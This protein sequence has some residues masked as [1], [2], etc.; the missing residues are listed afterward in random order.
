MKCPNCETQNPEDARF[1]FNCGTT[2]ALECSN[3]GTTLPAKAKF[4]FNCGHT[5]SAAEKSQPAPESTQTPA[6]AIAETTV[7]DQSGQL[8][9]RYIPQ[10][11][12]AK[13]EAAQKSGLMEGERRIVTIL[14]CDLKGSTSA[15][16]GLDPEE[17]SEIMNGAFEQ[18]IEPIYRYEGTVARLMGDGLLAFFGAPIA[19]EDD[20]QRAILAGLD[21]IQSMKGYGIEIKNNWGLALDV[22]VG[23]NTGLVVVGAVGSEGGVGGG[24][25]IAEGLSTIVSLTARALTFSRA[26]SSSR[27]VSQTSR[28]G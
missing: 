23:I 26:W 22:R 13:L 3:C 10:G 11:L 18:M 17:W 8:L 14:F 28:S 6:P 24:G 4:C 27:L 1:C 25:G 15:A 12:L 16:A 7:A 20:P 19:H 9:Q 2:L 5:T 21:I